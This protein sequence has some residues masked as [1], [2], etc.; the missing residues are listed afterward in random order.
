MTI[1]LRSYSPYVI[2]T[3]LH[4]SV[5]AGVA[6]FAVKPLDVPWGHRRKGDAMIVEIGF[7]APVN[8]ASSVVAESEIPV[9]TSGDVVVKEKKLPKEQQTLTQA[10]T[11]PIGG[12]VGFADGTHTGGEL[13]HER[14]R[15][16]SAKERYL[17]ELRV[18]IEG[19][20]HYPSI[21]RRLGES[22]KVIVEFVVNKEGEI[23][24]V[25]LKVPSSYSRLNVAA[26]D[27]VSGIRKFKPLPEGFSTEEARLEVP[28]DYTLN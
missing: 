21:S 3:L 1:A 8:P 2:S 18:L 25:N 5:F 16:A 4:F 28:I 17:Y 26:Q 11:A 10:T 15:E 14:G 12:Q 6:L 13:G 23:N 7:A 9:A 27:L 19:R 22:G 20:K 24:Q